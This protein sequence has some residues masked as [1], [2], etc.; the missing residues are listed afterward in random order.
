MSSGYLPALRKQ[1]K[2]RLRVCELAGNIVRFRDVDGG[3]E[4][5][6]VDYGRLEEEEV[7]MLPVRHALCVWYGE[8]GRALG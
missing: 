6:D 5:V 2:T 3:R 7:R 4:M 1:R 8:G